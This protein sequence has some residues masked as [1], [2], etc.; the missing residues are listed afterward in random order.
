MPTKE[1]R[2]SRIAEFPF[3]V[4]LYKSGV[5]SNKSSLKTIVGRGGI[6]LSEKH[7]GLFFNLGFKSSLN[8]KRYYFNV[9]V[10]KY[11]VLQAM[12]D[13]LLFR[14]IETYKPKAYRY[15]NTKFRGL[16]KEMSPIEDMHVWGIRSYME[17]V[18][19]RLEDYPVFDLT[20]KQ[21]CLMETQREA[22]IKRIQTIKFIQPALIGDSLLKMEAGSW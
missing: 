9:T 2:M 15:N 5:I 1:I 8:N 3:K 12:F 13:C 20:D 14:P 19:G 10:S 17:D 16:M 11:Y 18:L 6:S 22:L 21:H 7:N 4:D